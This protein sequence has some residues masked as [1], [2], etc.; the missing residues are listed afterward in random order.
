MSICSAGPMHSWPL[1]N[2]PFRASTKAQMWG[3]QYWWSCI[4]LYSTRITK[5]YWFN[6]RELGIWA[7]SIIN[8]GMTST[9]QSSYQ[10]PTSNHFLDT[11]YLRLLLRKSTDFAW[12]IQ[13]TWICP[14][15]DFI[16]SRITTTLCCK[17]IH[18]SMQTSM[19]SMNLLKLFSSF[20]STRWE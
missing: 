4:L 16:Y 10:L 19:E 3:M 8:D 12:N 5:H 9:I 20:K 15:W 18:H 7:T 14:L 1:Y 2:K 17:T 11:M 6:S 13:M